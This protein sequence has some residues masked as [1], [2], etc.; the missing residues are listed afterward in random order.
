[1]GDTGMRKFMRFFAF[2]LVLATSLSHSRNLASIRKDAFTVGVSKSDSATECDF[3]SEITA[4][5]KFSRFRIVTFEN[6]NAGQKLLLDGKIDAI[7][8]K[9]T[10]FPHLDNKF[11]VSQPYSKTEMAVATLAKNDKILTL[12]DLSG[13][14]L[15]FVPKDVSNEQVLGIWKNSKP[16]AVQSLVDAVNFLKKGEAD[17]IVAGRQSLEALKDSALRIFPNKLLENSIVALFAMESK[18][19]QDEFNKVLKTEVPLPS[20]SDSKEQNPETK[21]RLA[22]VLTLLNDLKK[23]IEMLQKELK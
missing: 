23:E 2:A 19:L 16:S 20:K 4:K 3:I 1:M 5:M 7:I 22:K 9:V 18:S 12:A 6:A 17:V 8:S 14:K 10:Y 21:E 11:L 13:K 15:A